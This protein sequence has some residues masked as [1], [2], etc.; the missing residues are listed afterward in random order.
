MWSM[1]MP[2]HADENLLGSYFSLISKMKHT[3]PSLIRKVECRFWWEELQGWNY[4][5][6]FQWKHPRENDGA[7]RCVGQT[8][9]TAFVKPKNAENVHCTFYKIIFYKKYIYFHMKGM[10][11]ILKKVSHLKKMPT[12]VKECM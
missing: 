8:S 4:A 6:H 5:L 10:T 3:C 11:V 1:L 2:M 9:I 7:N 12:T